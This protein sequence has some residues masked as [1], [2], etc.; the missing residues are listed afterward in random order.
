MQAFIYAAW[1]STCNGMLCATGDGFLNNVD[2]AVCPDAE[3]PNSYYY[4]STE[5][6]FYMIQP[7]ARLAHMRIGDSSQFFSRLVSRI[8]RY[9]Y[10]L[11]VNTAE[12]TSLL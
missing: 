5:N 8:C 3:V 10:Q 9:L 1:A 4:L 11:Q 6:V 2:N 7:L 12:M